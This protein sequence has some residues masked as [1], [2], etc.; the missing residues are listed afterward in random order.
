MGY[1]QADYKTVGTKVF[2]D[3]RGKR[4]PALVASMPFVPAN[5]KR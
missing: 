4:L 1:V 3:V 2:A 5:F